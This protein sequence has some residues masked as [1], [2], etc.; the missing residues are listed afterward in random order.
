MSYRPKLTI[1]EE[2]SMLSISDEKNVQDLQKLD[3]TEVNAIKELDVQSRNISEELVAIMRKFDTIDVT[4]KDLGAI[5]KLVCKI[6]K[7]EYLGQCA[8]YKYKDGI[9]YL[10]GAL[11]RYSNHCSDSNAVNPTRPLM[12]A[13]KEYG[14]D[15]FDIHYVQIAPICY[16]NQLETDYIKLRNSLTPNGYNDYAIG[17]VSYCGSES[18]EEREIRNIPIS[19]K[20]LEYCEELRVYLQRKIDNPNEYM[21]KKCDNDAAFRIRI[22]LDK[23]VSAPRKDGTVIPYENITVYVQT[24]N[25]PKAKQALKKKQGG[26]RIPIE[27]AYKKALKFIE[28]L[29]KREDCIIVDEA[30][31]KIKLVN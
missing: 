20:L 27:V 30:K 3:M 19:P 15:S 2:L 14:R 17:T 21:L 8:I 12:I 5:Y 23:N 10:Y 22:Q 7:K 28:D 1:L 13:L 9:P 26:V 6:T 31:D 25:K 18:S 4:D 11:G 24:G 29:N 16:L